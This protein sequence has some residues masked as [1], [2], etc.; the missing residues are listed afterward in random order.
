M[1]D[2]KRNRDKPD[3][4]LFHS[5]FERDAYRGEGWIFGFFLAPCPREE[6]EQGEMVRALVHLD[7]QLSFRPF[8]IRAYWW[9]FDPAD[10]PTPTR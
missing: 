7:G 10:R 8:R 3:F 6:H 5:W 1:A 2:T 4:P 9:F